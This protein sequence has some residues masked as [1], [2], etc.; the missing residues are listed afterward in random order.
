[1]DAVAELYRNGLV[2]RQGRLVSGP[3]VRQAEN[4]PEFVLVAK[5]KSGAGKDIII[6]QKDIH[7]IQL[8]K[9]A[10][11]TGIEVLLHE[12]NITWEEIDE[13]II[14]GGFGT[15]INPSSAIAT[16]M[17]PPVPLKRLRDAG[18]AAGMGAKMCLI[19]MPQRA[20]ATEIAQ[21][22]VSLNLMNYPGFADEFVRNLPFPGN[23]DL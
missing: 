11:R 15:A 23:R 7:E 3:G 2:T 17:F 14:A 16:G 10:I 6:T 5:G 22:I 13:I 18:N 19:S 9:A 20:K 1:M 8:A 4:G 21:R 12:M